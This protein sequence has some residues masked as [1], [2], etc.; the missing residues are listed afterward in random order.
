M[1][2]PRK[3]L[4]VTISEEVVDR[5]DREADARMIGKGVIVEKALERFLD[6]LPPIDATLAIQ[7]QVADPTPAGLDEEG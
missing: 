2:Q 4:S 1:S 7:D 3:P 6:G 5:L